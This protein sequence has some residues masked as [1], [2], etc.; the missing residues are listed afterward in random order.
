MTEFLR[1]LIIGKGRLATH[2]EHYLGLLELPFVTWN[3]NSPESLESLT[4]EVTHVLI[5]INDDQ[6]ESFL[7]QNNKLSNKICVHCSGSLST[8]LAHSAHPI[9]SFSHELWEKSQYT[10]IP[11]VI[12]HGVSFN[13]ILP[14]LPNPH[15]Q[16]M[17]ENKALYHALCVMASN[18]PVLLWS[19]IEKN[20]ED[21][22]LPPD[23]LRQLISQ[24]HKNFSQLG[25][26]A[27]TGPLTRGDQKSIDKNLA[28]LKEPALKNIYQSF[29]DAYADQQQR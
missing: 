18:F 3:R 27:L 26:Q 10:Q 15:H 28:S 13:H 23:S 11:F 8:E 17:A 25:Y 7:K 9:M 12:T 6:I 29:I 5:L 24:S 14:G 20:I 21:M 22:G 19:I 16:L 4:H 1:Y 2:F